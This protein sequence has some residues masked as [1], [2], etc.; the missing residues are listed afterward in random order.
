MTVEMFL[1]CLFPGGWEVLAQLSSGQTG[2]SPQGLVK[3]TQSCMRGV[4]VVKEG[5]SNLHAG[6]RKTVPRKSLQ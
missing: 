2:P 5:M 4:M 1:V 3:L 6:F